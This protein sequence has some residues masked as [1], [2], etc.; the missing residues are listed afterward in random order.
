MPYK[1]RY[2]PRARR[3]RRRI[4]GLATR[5]RFIPRGLAAKR[6]QQVS[7][8][9]FYFKDNGTLVANV[10]RK[11]RFDWLVQDLTGLTPPAQFASLKLLYEEYKVIA[12]EV[13]IFPAGVGT[14]ANTA[15][16][17]GP[18]PFRRGDTVLWQDQA[19][20]LK[21][22]T[23]DISDLIN[24][25]S[26]RMIDSRRKYKRTLYRPKGHPRWGTIDPAVA[27][28]D[29]WT[30]AIS[31]LSADTSAPAAPPAE[32]RLWYWTRCYKVV[33]RGRVQN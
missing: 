21:D 28:P 14:E 16:V 11:T 25:A 31:I 7:T 32:L 10:A 15:P 30:G 29:D 8:K 18:G 4:P 33:V 9:T 19:E 23:A 3:T 27:L 2:R 6:F 17:G 5:S 22:P 13:R 12:M 24:I 20:P 1:R 26:C